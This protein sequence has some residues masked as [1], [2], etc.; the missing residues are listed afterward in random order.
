MSRF[1]ARRCSAF[2]FALF[3]SF[4]L[5]AATRLA[6]PTTPIE[7]AKCNVEDLEQ[8][9]DSQLHSI[10]HDITRTAFFRTFHVDL[11]RKCPLR[12]WRKEDEDDEFECAAKEPDAPPLCSIA[13]DDNNNNP[14]ASLSLESNALRTI[15]QAGFQ[16][17]AQKETFSWN[18]HSD[19]VLESLTDDASSCNGHLLPD[20]FWID[21]CPPPHNE[22]D[23]SV[24][25]NLQSNPEHNTGYNGTHIWRAVYEENCVAASSSQRSSPSSLLQDDNDAYC[26]EE[27]VLYRL[28]SG[29]HTQ[30]TLS[31]A[32]NYYPP[33]K[34]KGRDEWEPNPD[35]FMEKFANGKNSDYIRN[36]HFTYVVLLRALH[37]AAPFLRAYDIRTG[38]VVHDE[39][40][41]VLLRRLLD[42]AILG[43]CNS[44]FEAFDESIMFKKD[45]QD[46]VSLQQNFK[47]VFH[48]VSSILDCVQCQQ[49]KLHGKLTMLGYGAALKVLFMRDIHLERNEIVA[50]INTIA[51]VSESVRNVRE[52]T[53]MYWTRLKEGNKT[54]ST[55]AAK[56]TSVSPLPL[57]DTSG[58]S[59]SIK[60]LGSSASLENVDKAVEL[61][62]TLGRTGKIA[63][64]KESEI[65]QLALNR[66]PELLI[67]AKHYIHDPDKFLHLLSQTHI[68][69]KDSGGTEP[70]A[71][72][73][74]SGLAGLAAALNILDR[75]GRVIVIEK[76]HSLGGNS[77]KASSGINAC[78]PNNST[79]SLD[80][81]RNDTAKSAGSSLKP[82]LVET[83]VSK[84]E[85]AVN[86]LKQRVGVDLSLV[87]QLGGHSAKR[88]HRPNNGMVGAEIIYGMQKAVKL[89]QK[90][91]M[92]KILTDTK[93]TGL[94]T[95]ASGRVT[96]VKVVKAVDP[97]SEEKEIR[98][99][100]TILSTGGFAADRSPG[101]LLEV[102]R[103]ELLKMPTTAG[104]YS[105]GD[106][107][108]LAKT[109]G[110]GVVDM[111]KVQVHPTGWVDP[112]NPNST[113]KVLAGEL[114]RGVGGILLNDDGSRF[115][116]EL[117]IRSYVTKEMLSHDPNF[118]KTGK[119]NISSVIPNFSLILSSSA[120]E[121]GKK[122]VD[123]YTHKGLMTKVDGIRGLA[124]TTG[125]T[126]S[127]LI[128]TLRKYQDDAAKGTDDF[129]KSSF[130]G[131]PKKDL[132]NETFYV[133]RVTPV[134]H[135]CMGGI[136]I[137]VNGTVLREDGEPILGLYAAGEV[138]GGVH[139]VNRLGGNSLLECTVYGTIVGQ[140]IPITS[141][142]LPPPS[143]PLAPLSP[144]NEPNNSA[145]K[146]V[147]LS[148]L[149]MHNT[150]DDCWV[151][152]HGVAYD[153]TDFAEEHPAG[154][155]SIHELCGKEG[156]DAFAAIHN[157][158]MLDDFADDV[159]G[160]F[161]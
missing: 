87:A 24:D 9:N 48:N 65:V 21:L 43:S 61:A 67:L 63:L 93:V 37:K 106:G 130:R 36:L 69:N 7:D 149:Q 46:V 76:E 86:W 66:N 84:S 155:Q 157:S 101:S 144:V 11:E 25:I 110:A 33:S 23:K 50:L 122:H 116:N 107:I 141:Q 78:C 115:C 39:T 16:S 114:L 51:K 148:E 100:N 32:M 158:Q 72:V 140:K 26:T 14:F 102:Y 45:S 136:T 129:G 92:V 75:G 97:E 131:V 81:F 27:R 127:A 152:I 143:A 62:S 10:L 53:N 52:L 64:A 121:D 89:Y 99:F 146:V 6:P 85:S 159:K 95:D 8:A 22:N 120:A 4:F 20:S 31:I 112:K 55:I 153:L 12:Q 145:S 147:S 54:P 160:K 40:A 17:Q 119:W 113:N 3:V 94:L 126:E 13:T 41:S 79:D 47:G 77:N 109:L 118:R 34:R 139:G 30:T 154:P 96:G 132:E 91:G 150:A 98:S 2:F 44:V 70:D 74:G 156:T 58:P 133:G 59:A 128:K 19:R 111:D 161:I 38:N 108:A 49:C 83:L 125:L 71:I 35:Y 68:G 138:T 142:V 135:Y 134:L 104:E 82:E 124:I 29:M 60:P 80:S 57:M 42:S 18:K 88:T 73:V 5:A 123:H 103:P 15:S 137:D 1:F 56:E 105:T 151:A 28:L 117:G 90:S